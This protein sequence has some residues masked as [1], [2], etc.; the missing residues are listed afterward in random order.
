MTIELIGPASFDEATAERCAEIF[1]AQ[2]AAAGLSNAPMTGASLAAQAKFTHDNR[3]FDRIWLAREG[4][5]VIGFASLEFSRWDNEHMALAF[6]VVHPDHHGRGLGRELL[7]AQVGET[8]AVGRTMLLTFTMRD[9]PAQKMLIEYGF[10]IAQA[11]AQRRL[12]P[13]DVDYTVIQG[14]ADE[15]AR[16][17][18]DYEIVRLNG[19]APEEWLEELVN[20]F[21]AMNDA[22]L[23]DIDLTPDAFPVERMRRY[24]AAMDAR[25][26]HLYRMMARHKQTREWAGHTILCADTLRPGVAMQEDTT[27]VEAHR[28]H[29]LGMWLKASMLLWTHDEQPDLQTIDTWNAESNDHMIAVNDQLGCFVNGRGTALQ[30]HL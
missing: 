3:P 10:E 30:L 17:A 18:A 11:T 19:A 8:R 9:T 25:G 2:A 22:P 7:E 27:V 6:C 21:E 1:N 16:H 15:A 5:D 29:R 28:G 20:L 26:Q 13:Q 12:R 23:D 4:N 24:E 14:L